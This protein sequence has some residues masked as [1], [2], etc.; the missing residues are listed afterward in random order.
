MKP[1]LLRKYYIKNYS[2]F[3]SILNNRLHSISIPRSKHSSVFKTIL[4]TKL[5]TA[6]N[7]LNNE[8]DR[9]IEVLRTISGMHVFY[10]ELFKIETG[11]EPENLIKVFKKLKNS[12]KKIYSEYRVLIKNSNSGETSI[13]FKKGLARLI[14]IYKRKRRIIDSIK[15]SLVELSKLPD[16]AGDYI[17]IIAGMP[18]VGKSTLLS[19]LT[20]A[21][22][23][24]SPFPFTTKTVIVGHIVGENDVKITLIDTPG[25]LDRP[26]DYKNPIELKAIIAL[27]HLAETILYLFDPSPLSYYSLDEQINVLDSIVKFTGD[28]DILILVNKVDITPVEELNKIINMIRNKYSYEVIPISAETGY[29]IDILKKKLIEKYLEKQLLNNS[30]KP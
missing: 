15:N 11:C 17:V 8:L 24:I 13:Y 23:E 28:R 27:K 7:M 19:R 26:I 22:P 18:Q 4:L 21:K 20:R 10:R 29:N 6:Y 12:A 14:S 30:R 3:Y 25:L 9:I 5:N 1:D 16:I 2:E